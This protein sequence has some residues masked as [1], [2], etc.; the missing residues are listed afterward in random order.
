[1]LNFNG[2]KVPE[3]LKVQAIHIQTLPAIET[4]LKKIV[5][6]S[7][8][9]AGR[10]DLGE[11]VIKCD[12]IVVIPEGYSL[13]KCGR[14]LAVWIRGNDFKLSPLIIEDDP[15]IQYLA[16]ISNSVD[17]S[18]LLFVGSGSIE[19]VVPSGDS[20][21]I[22][23]VTT[24]G[25]KSVTVNNQG[26]K[27]TFPVIEATIG[28]NVTAGSIVLQNITSGK[29]AVFSGTFKAG[30]ILTFDCNKHLVKLDNRLDISMLSI[31][32]EFFELL[33]GSNVIQMNNEKTKIV[34]THKVKYL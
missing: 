7:G 30:Q 11:K 10:S 18:D 21:L 33:E 27:A 19:F 16:K 2:V 14:E 34:V 1:M 24:S 26:T 23:P 25:T 3:F 15:E 9:I 28:T 8:R 31:E 12:V 17:L 29:K 5:G 4:N 13:Q 20:E 6:S 22:R 32:S